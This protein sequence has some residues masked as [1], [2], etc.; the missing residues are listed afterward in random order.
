LIGRLGLRWPAPAQP[1]EQL[2]ATPIRL[3]TS[4]ILVVFS[5]ASSFHEESVFPIVREARPV[6]LR[7]TLPA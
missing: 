2:L 6:P 7:P 3:L 5:R 4:D 1:R